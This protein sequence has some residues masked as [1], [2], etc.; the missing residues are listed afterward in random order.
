MDIKE[1]TIETV[2]NFHLVFRCYRNIDGFGWWYRGQADSRWKL[3]PKAGRAEFHLPDNRDIGRFNMWR[4]QAIAYSPLP[5]SELEQLALAQ[6]HG[7]ATRLLDWSRNPLVAS[8]FA[9]FEYPDQDGAVYILESPFQLFT[10]EMDLDRLI[11]KTGIFGY[12]PKAISP[13][14]LNQK[15]LFT[16]HC[17]PSRHIDIEKS[18]NAGDHP[19]LARLIIPARLKKDILGLLEDYGIDRSFM[20]PDLDGLSTHINSKTRTLKKGSK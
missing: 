9:C 16:V 15:G 20:F 1:H 8:Y 6:H 11:K 19:N 2:E 17:E 18:R 10:E 5:D 4:R 12:H 13:R 3:L 7:L 14:V